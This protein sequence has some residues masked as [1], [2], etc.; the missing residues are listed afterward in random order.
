M[1]DPNSRGRSPARV[2]R[3]TRGRAGPRSYRRAGRGGSSLLAVFA[4]LLL[5][6]A[7]CSGETPTTTEPLRLLGTSLPEAVVDEPY[8]VDLEPVGGLRPYTF[9]LEEGRLPPGVSL[10]GGRLLGTPTELGRFEFAVAVSDA[11]LASTFRRYTLEVREVPVPTVTLGP[12]DTEVRRPVTLRLRVSEARRF[13]AARLRVEWD[14][15]RF[16][17][18]AD[19]V[20][21]AGAGVAVLH[22]AS[23]G[24]LQLDAAVLGEPA[25]GE[26][27]LARFELVPVEP[28]LLQISW[29]AELLYAGRHHYVERSEGRA[30][31]GSDQDGPEDEQAEDDQ[32][33]AQEPDEEPGDRQDPENGDP[34]ADEEDDA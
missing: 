3:T 2:D 8:Q 11:N 22:E 28:S 14:A 23:D 4:T 16:E 34:D 18:N 21:S 19:S 1:H 6:V 32:G 5:L 7:A 29:E 33:D 20:S 31:S 15:E 17:L 9:T 30:P 12:P 24:R 13:R 10:Q 25:D 26:I 27:E